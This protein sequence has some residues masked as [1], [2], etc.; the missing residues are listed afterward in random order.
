MESL[1]FLRSLG[2]RRS[3]PVWTRFP[4]PLDTIDEEGDAPEPKGARRRRKLSEV[5]RI[6][7]LASLPW[8][9]WLF[10]YA[11]VL[12]CFSASRC[13]VLKSLVT[14]YGSPRD[15]TA[16]FKIAALTLGFMEDFVCA[17]YLTC[18]LWL[19]DTCKLAVVNR[20]TSRG[21][22]VI[23]RVAGSFATFAVSWLSFVVMMAPFAA[24]LL[25]VINRDM[26]FT[27][28]LVATLIRE[29]HHLDAAPIST[30]EIQRA[31]MT[32]ALVAGAATI[33]A[34]VR[35]CA[36]W[37]DLAGWNPTHLVVDPSNGWGRSIKLTTGMGGKYEE[38]ALEEGA[39]SPKSPVLDKL[40]SANASSTY[41]SLIINH[42]VQAT[43]VLSGLVVLPALVVAVRCEC[44][45]LVAYSALNATLNELF[46]HALQPAPTDATFTNVNDN[47]WVEMYIHPTERH[48]LF[49]DDSLYRLTTGF[50]GDVA[51]DVSVSS[52]NPPNVL[53][54]GVE[55]FRYRDSRYMVG[56]DDPSNLFKDTDLTITPNFDRWAKRGVAL[57]N[58]WTSN[59]TSRSLESIQFAQIP[60]DSAT[61][62]GITGGRGDTQ[63][64]G[65]PQLFSAKGY[66]TFFSTGSS[67]D[68]DNWDIFLPSHGFETVWDNNKMIELAEADYNISH[69]EWNGEEHRG[70]TW[71]VHDDLSFQILGDLLVNKTRN[72][73]EQVTRGEPK[74]PL[75][76]T[77]YT[78]T[79]HAPFN[80]WPTWY[81]KSEKPDFSAL[82]EGE[83]HAEDI[84]RYLEARYFTDLELGRFL[85]R[86]S[87]EG[88]LKDTIVLI[89]GDH[90]QAPEAE[91]IYSEEES[92]TRVPCAIIA[93]GR[94]GKDTG[95]VIEDAAE[96]Y[97]ILNTLADITGVPEGGFVQNGV[98]R[99]LKRKVTFGE[100]AVFSNVP[101]HKMSVV[102]GNQ[103]LRYDSVTDAMLLHNTETDYFMAEDLFPGLSP[104]KQAEWLAWRDN[105]RRISA[106]Y[107]KRWDEN[108]LLAVNC[109]AEM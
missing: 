4:E 41:R 30:E 1:R 101:G 39:A 13:V 103:R 97:D 73:T 28:D 5:L 55:S 11:F 94:L 96:H 47:Q 44:S 92:M 23:V 93:E 22:A 87:D 54:I 37:A 18:V 80:A 29:R 71:G 31:Y 57:R 81:D 67:I 51:F 46:G 82:Y 2:S 36:G 8:I 74:K 16:S 65:L 102:R 38:V 15:Y 7:D 66:E 85:D 95:L 19:F 63:L 107:T 62:T 98:G 64:A 33:F 79:S 10:V 27:L 60:Y 106:Y 35:A 108:C 9:G 53:V 104:D 105:G 59:P 83:E 76:I 78:I 52:D 26:R 34:L 69:E 61:Q 42:T 40:S 56:K 72:Q 109:T 20:F 91:V 77:H 84:Q 99:S 89:M 6:Q 86:M 100:R 45:P 75:F 58:L 49:G 25:L 14:M 70:F 50:R 24:D 88:V 48:K 21:R 3:Q 17:T 90:G 12:F 68:L 43:L 32:A